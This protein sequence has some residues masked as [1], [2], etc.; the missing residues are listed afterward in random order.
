M[1]G[2]Q[3]WHYVEDQETSEREQTMLEL[4]SLGLDTVGFKSSFVLYNS[5][6]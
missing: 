6:T 5:G 1:E 3:T 4:H 2:R